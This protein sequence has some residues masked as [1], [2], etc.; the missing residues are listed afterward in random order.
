MK[1]PTLLVSDI[2]L[3]GNP[4]D[5]YR[6]ALFP[7]L[8]QTCKEEKVKTVIML[9]DLTD[10][11]DYHSAALANR[12]VSSVKMIADVV[13]ETKILVGNHDW[14]LSGQEYFRFLSMLPG[15]EYITKPTE[16][17]NVKGESA[18]FLPYSKA[19]RKEWKGLDFSHYQY[20]FMHQTIKGAR[21]SNGQAME[22][23]DLPELNAGKV[24][25]GDIHVPQVIGGVEYV[26][27][28]FHVHFGDR[29]KP[30]CVLIERGGRAV[31]LHFDTISRVTVHVANLRELKREKFTKGD[32]IKLRVELT[33]AEK[34]EWQR[35]RRECVEHL[36]SEGVEVHG[37]E[38]IVKK[39]SRRV[40]NGEPTRAVRRTPEDTVLR[41][42]ESEELGGDALD[43]AL[44]IVES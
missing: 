21:S 18:F 6:W 39:S 15:V 24:Y 14:L 26:G 20:L 9:G 25:S 43:I 33:E 5:E 11:K 44:E 40:V 8:A 3:T 27:S 2:H 7:W 42:V 17:S 13:E 41:Y 1:L 12:V 10:A 4:R 36:K 31:D 23:E 38:L 32:Q 35:I 30:R 28:P 34:H 29:F 16:D 22:G 37:V 19:P